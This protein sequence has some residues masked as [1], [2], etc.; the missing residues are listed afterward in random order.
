MLDGE[1]IIMSAADSTFFN[2]NE[3]ATLIWNAADGRTSLSE[4]VSNKVC[5]TFDVERDQAAQDA[6][7]FVNQL[8]SHG[9]LLVSDQPIVDPKAFPL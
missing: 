1:M 5:A 3:V 8:S 9:I 4:I 7:E 2:L 6:E